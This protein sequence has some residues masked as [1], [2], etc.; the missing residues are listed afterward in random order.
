MSFAH[1]RL[2]K[3]KEDEEE[4]LYAA[5]SP[6][7]N[8]AHEWEEVARLSVSRLHNTH[9]FVPKN[10]WVDQKVVPPYV[11]GLNEP[12]MRQALASEFSGHAYGA[13]TGRILSQVRKMQEL[14]LYPD[15]SP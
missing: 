4:V 11:Y 2:R 10:A 9:T 7:F 1:I 5:L 3:L 12:E 15:E 13:W 14:G 8:E 6:D